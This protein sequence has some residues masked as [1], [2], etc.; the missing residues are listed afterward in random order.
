MIALHVFLLMPYPDHLTGGTV[1]YR[2]GGP[3]LE[4]FATRSPGTWRTRATWSETL[5]QAG[6]SHPR[7]NGGCRR[8][9]SRRAVGTTPGILDLLSAAWDT[10]PAPPAPRGGREG[11]GSRALHVG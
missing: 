1:A 2:L 9:R 8:E 10:E 7:G 3:F 11:L 5:S 6:S 4:G